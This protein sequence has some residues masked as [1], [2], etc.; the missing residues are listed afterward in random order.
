MTI[1]LQGLD[2]SAIA[3]A[4]AEKHYSPLEVAQATLS[5]IEDLNGDLHAFCAIDPS[6]VLRDAEA[7]TAALVGGKALGPLHGVPVAIKDLIDVSGLPTRAGMVTSSADPVSTD[8]P[9][10]TALKAAGAIILGKVQLTEGAWS[11]HHPEL[12]A[13]INPRGAEYWTGVSSSGSGVA[14]GSRM[15]SLA[16]GSD[17]AGSIRFP[18]YANGIVGFKPSYDMVSREGV[19]PLSRSF[20]HIGPMGLSVKDCSLAMQALAGLQPLTEQ[21]SLEGVTVGVDRAWATRSCHPIVISAFESAL[22][23]LTGLGARLAEVTAPQFLSGE[24]WNL[25]CAV[26]AAEVHRHGFSVHPETFGPGLG[27]LVQM[28]LAVTDTHLEHLNVSRAQSDGAWR[29]LLGGIDVLLAPVMPIPVPTL[30]E[31]ALALSSPEDGGDAVRFT[32]PFAGAG[33]PALTLPLGLDLR[34]MPSALQI[35]GAFGADA[36]VLQIGRTI[37]AARG[38]GALSLPPKAL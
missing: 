32:V 6:R 14:V 18:S 36:R 3:K 31:L 35:I 12:T 24:D 19:F 8:A 29:K 16:L 11:L 17:T 34:G 27:P 37:E 23:L 21:S 25:L 2:A 26:E 22:E 33:V 9:C 30:A 13:P 4:I 10:V 15:A 38:L 20:D 1:D 5:R 28:G 7:A